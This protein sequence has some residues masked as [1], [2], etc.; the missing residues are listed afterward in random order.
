MLLSTE[1]YAQTINVGCDYHGPAAWGY[2]GK[3]VRGNARQ[4]TASA[5]DRALL[6]LFERSVKQA[7]AATRD[8][9]VAED[10]AAKALAPVYMD[11]SANPALLDDPDA[12]ERRRFRR[13]HGR[14]SNW[15]RSRRSLEPRQRLLTLDLEVNAPEPADDPECRTRGMPS[16]TRP[17]GP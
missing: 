6:G 2:Q 11:V 12:L 13:V 10:L 15:R 14:I 1:A 17:C 4:V 5:S 8:S 9:D 7:F 3:L 16:S